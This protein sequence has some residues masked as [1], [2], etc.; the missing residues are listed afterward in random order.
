MMFSPDGVP[1]LDETEDGMRV[2]VI[3]IRA[4]VFKDYCL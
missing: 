4:T 2:N 1:T 3:R